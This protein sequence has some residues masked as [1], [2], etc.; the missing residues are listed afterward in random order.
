MTNRVLVPFT[1]A[2]GS[3]FVAQTQGSA[4][5]LACLAMRQAYGRPATRIGDGGS[6]PL[7]TAFR[8]TVPSAAIILWGA[9][10][11]GSMIHALNESVDLEELRRCILAETLFLEGLGSLTAMRP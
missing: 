10:D 7:V 1:V 4:F 8:E 9:A 2:A 3:G 11:P 6:I 5:E